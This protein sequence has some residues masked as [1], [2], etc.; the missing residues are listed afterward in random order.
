MSTRGLFGD[1]GVAGAM[2]FLASLR[3]HRWQRHRPRNISAVYYENNDT[4]LEACCAQESS[5]ANAKIE[6]EQKNN[7]KQKPNVTKR[8]LSVWLWHCGSSQGFHHRNSWPFPPS[9]KPVNCVWLS[10]FGCQLHVV[11]SHFWTDVN[12]QQSTWLNTGQLERWRRR[13]IKLI[14]IVLYYQII[15]ISYNYK[16]FI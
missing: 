6:E 8:P 10:I 12:H 2:E 14:Y 3:I 5:K 7:T 1:G 11:Q 9:A 16:P 4:L 13:Q 15:T